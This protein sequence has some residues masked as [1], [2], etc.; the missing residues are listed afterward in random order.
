MKGDRRAVSSDPEI[1]PDAP[2][3]PLSPSREVQSDG[4]RLEKTTTPLVAVPPSVQAVMRPITPPPR[5]TASSAVEGTTRRPRI[6]A[7]TPRPAPPRATYVTITHP[8]ITR[9]APTIFLILDE[10]T[11]RQSRFTAAQLDDMTKFDACLR[12]GDAVLTDNPFGYLFVARIFNR[13]APA[14]IS[15]RFATYNPTTNQIDIAAGLPRLA[16]IMPP[17]APTLYRPAQHY[18]RHMP[19]PPYPPQHHP[20]SHYGSVPAFAGFDA[21]QAR[22]NVS[23]QAPKKSRRSDFDFD[24]R[25]HSYF[26]SGYPRHRNSDNDSD[27][28]MF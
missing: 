23:R 14:S 20:V 24:P 3:E 10:K 1:L 4:S 22:S 19:P 26:G 9:I 18:S 13:C 2:P 21:Q 11:N 12:R 7:P 5:A 8:S 27:S 28:A 15:L 16:P 25:P 6:L 17:P